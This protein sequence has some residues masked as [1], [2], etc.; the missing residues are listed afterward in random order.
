AVGGGDGGGIRRGQL[1]SE[2]VNAVVVGAECVRETTQRREGL[3]KARARLRSR[4]GGGDGEADGAGV[5]GSQLIA[6]VQ[7]L[8]ERTE[9]LIGLSVLGDDHLQM[10]GRS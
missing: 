3:A 4:I 10:R 9:R 2:E 1:E 7:R 8:D 5:L 6:G